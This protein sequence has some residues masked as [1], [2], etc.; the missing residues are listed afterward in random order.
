MV[1][2]PAS[3]R[4][5]ATAVLRRPVVLMMFF[6]SGISFFF[7]APAVSA[8]LLELDRHWLLRGVRVIGAAVDFE[9]GEKAPAQSVLRQ[10]STD[11]RL[12]QSLGFLLTH[13]ARRS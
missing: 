9:L 1:P 7:A 13:L 2:D 11:C 12:E 10:H 5:L 8:S 4:T 6:F 3:S